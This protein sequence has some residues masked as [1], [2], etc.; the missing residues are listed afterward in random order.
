MYGHRKR[1]NMQERTQ[2]ARLIHKQGSRPE[3]HSVQPISGQFT[4]TSNELL[5]R[6]S[7]TSIQ[8]QP[9]GIA[10]ILVVVLVLLSAW[11]SLNI[12]INLPEVLSLLSIMPPF[13]LLQFVIEIGF[14]VLSIK[15]II[16]IF[17]RKKSVIKFAT[18]TMCLFMASGIAGAISSILTID[19]YADIFG[20]RSL[21]AK[22]LQSTAPTLITSLIIYLTIFVLMIIFIRHSKKL[23]KVLVN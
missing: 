2:K 6:T 15:I 19:F 11:L 23:K 4:T 18:I 22:L 7:T 3:I 20:S 8:K 21:T 9:L 17:E 16:L 5:S 13:S 10:K 12:L 14:V 1:R